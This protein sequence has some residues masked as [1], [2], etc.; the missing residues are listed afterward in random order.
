[1]DWVINSSK[2]T[3]IK[4]LAAMRDAKDSP[5]KVSTGRPT[6]SAS[7]AVVPAL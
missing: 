2:P 5:A 1:M 4:A 6:Q 7:L 3:P